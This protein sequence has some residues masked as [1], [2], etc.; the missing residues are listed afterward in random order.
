MKKI[1]VIVPIY[2]VEEYLDACI[3]S[4]VNQTYKNLE[5]IL[6]DDGS[7]D[8]CGEMCDA[9]AKADERIKV[10][11]KENGGLS[12]ARN[13]GMKAAGGE[14]IGFVDS[15]DVIHPRMYERLAAMMEETGS[16]ISCCTVTRNLE[17]CIAG[18]DSHTASC[19][20]IEVFDGI[21]ALESLLSLDR[22]SVT[23]WNKLYTREVIED[24]YFPKGK[25]HE[26]EFWTYLV[27]SRAKKAAHTEQGYYGYRI[28]E[29]SITNQKYTSR[30]LDHLD[31][32][33]ERLEYMEMHYPQFHSLERTNI[34][35]ESIRAM[36]LC[37]L[38]MDGRELEDC[39]ERIHK[40]VKKYPLKYQDYKALPFG[41]KVWCFLSNRS[42]DFTC[43]LRNRFHFGP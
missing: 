13:A 23:V 32:R 11:H 30:H 5:I 2:K 41:R 14:L 12:D 17:A 25:Y 15:D 22:I 34:R 18:V 16:D 10:I 35:F 43:H 4:I 36:Q 1:S 9:W 19:P 40:I 42:F 24:L 6:V 37:Y 3:T 27:L 28:R 20:E 8:L 31:A 21:Q 26:D 29:N 38:F 7:P 39:R 33:A